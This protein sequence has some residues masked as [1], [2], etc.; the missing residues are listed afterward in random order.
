MKE[1]PGI[2][3]LALGSPIIRQP[4]LFDAALVR[5]A[6]C[7]EDG[8]VIVICPTPVVFANALS[9]VGHRSVV[10]AGASVDAGFVRDIVNLG[11]TPVLDGGQ[12]EA[13]ELGGA[14]GAAKVVIYTDLQGVMSA[15]PANVS[16]A[17]SVR[18]VSHLELMELADQ[19]ASPISDDAAHEASV[20]GVSYEIRRVTDNEGTVIRADGYE[21]RF[22]PITSI[23]VSSGYGL[24]SMGAK[25][26]EAAVWKDLQMRILERIASAG[27]SIEMLQSFAFGMRFLAPIGRLS[28]MQTLAEEYG[29]AFQGIEGCAKLCIV[30][31]GVRSTAGVFYR[32]LSSLAEQNVPVLHWSDSNV[33]MSFVVNNNFARLSEKTLHTALA[34]GS[35]IS[36]GAAISFDADLG[37]V[38]MNGR[39]VRLGARQAQLLRYLLDNVGRIVEAEELARHLF[40]ADGKEELAAVRVHLH[41]LRKKIEDNPD[42]PRFIVT[43]PEQGY[44][45]MR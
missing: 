7:R 5:V 22:S 11:G 34:P 39:E 37:L 19:G 1:T 30:G 36:V 41:N 45:F 24:V 43:V 29:L 25:A 12:R 6:E 9:N 4:K 21:D 17:I 42:T 28:F 32:S 23:T 20:N 31:T 40:D 3:V 35:D 13:I 18:Y 27:I 26:P 44:L 38:R 16:D 10:L 33:T 15:N 2:A 8:G 14:I